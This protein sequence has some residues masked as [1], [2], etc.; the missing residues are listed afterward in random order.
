MKKWLHLRWLKW[1]ANGIRN[2]ILLAD[3]RM[4]RAHVTLEE[5]GVWKKS[6]QKRLREMDAKIAAAESPQGIIKGAI[7]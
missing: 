2:D 1:Q 6:A 7:K 4:A 3:D 5:L